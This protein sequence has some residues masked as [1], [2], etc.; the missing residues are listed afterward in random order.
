MNRPLLTSALAEAEFHAWYWLKAELAAFCRAEGLL[1][2]GS[3][4][5][6]AA[7]IAAHLASRPL[8]ARAP[9]RCRAAR[10][11]STFH[12]E[13]IIGEGW[14]CTQALRGFF[15]TQCGKNFAFNEPLRTFIATG[16][17]HTLADALAHYRQSL[18]AAPRPIA[19]QF[20]YNTHM[21]AF[22]AANPSGTHAAAVSAWW[23]KRG[24]ADGA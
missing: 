19:K 20:E 17:G 13:T 16:Q 1:A 10:M 15:E 6:L 14:R 8:P 21:R 5:E 3:K 24:K 7:H 4:L 22:K 18:V 12:A 9:R 11:P 2:S 23:R